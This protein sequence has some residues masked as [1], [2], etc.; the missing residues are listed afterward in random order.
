[1]IRTD[2]SDGK[3]RRIMVRTS[4]AVAAL[5]ASGLILA[6]CAS[7]TTNEGE[8]TGSSD[9]GGST[10]TE[11]LAGGTLYVLTQAE[12]FLHL[13]PQRNY[14]GADLAFAGATMHRT[15][16]TYDADG[17]IIPDLATDTGR[18]S[19]GGKTWEFTL[20]DGVSFEDGSPITCADV[21]YGMSR[22]FAGDVITD[23][24][25]FL[26]AYLDAEGYEGPYTGVGQE[27]YD[28]AFQ[29]LDD[30]NMSIRLKTPV[31]DFNGAFTLLI[32]SPVP[33]AADTGELYDNAPVS[34]GPYKIESY[35]KG[36]SL[37]LVRNENWDPASDPVRKAYP[38]EIIVEFALDPKV[39][40]ERLI[41]S[42]GPDS[43]AIS[44]GIQSENLDRVFG[45][46]QLAARAFD[47]YDPYVRYI[48]INTA[49]VPCLAVRKALYYGL[50]RSGILTVYGGKYGGELADG[51]IKPNLPI[52]YRPV[53]GYDDLEDIGN[54]DLAT[55][56]MEQAKTDCP[57]D[58]KRATETGLTFDYASTPTGEKLAAILIAS[59]D[60]NAGVKITPNPIE[61]G[62][63]YGVVLDPGSQG[64]L[65]T[66]GWGPD[67]ANASTVVPALFTPDGGFDLSR[68]IEGDPEAYAEF[69][70]LV[71]AGKGETD[72]E[73]QGQIW[74]DGNQL[75]MERV[76]V[77]PTVFG[78]S[79]YIIGDKVG[80][81]YFWDAYG[82]FNI[83]DIYVSK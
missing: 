31:I 48:A 42:S 10:A 68:A 53:T 76:W 18:T 22:S 55:Q 2:W 49:S 64:D 4:K 80:G 52:D 11:S 33:A 9:S 74:A 5:L 83:A 69:A 46:D 39:I 45:D 81:A 24:P 1:M 23:G 56:W 78:R 57:A 70:E 12:Q 20:R 61:P 65:N 6:G 37:K 77:L 44:Y 30:K 25:Y 32:S 73:A 35:D 40:D 62:Q 72:R 15:L 67:W 43:A 34:S 51:V 75:A 3:I 21:K 54:K 14:T 60:D 16:V 59:M 27:A 71:A 17:N 41:A 36:V 66:A 63:Y 79:Q 19:D 47:V 26:V 50:D 38:D 7:A 58:Y 82:W 28:D 8:S 13:D 29:C